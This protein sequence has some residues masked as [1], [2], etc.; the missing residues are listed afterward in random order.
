MRVSIII[1]AH[2]EERLLP[3]TLAALQAA[4][5][6]LVQP[7][8]IIVVNDAST[9]RTAQIARAHGVRVLDVDL[10]QISAVRNAGA[11]VATGDVL[12]FVDADTLVPR[13]T[14]RMALGALR[15]G[16]VGG[17][18]Q[19]QF[20][21]IS[22]FQHQ[23]ARAFAS[24]WLSLMRLA[25][26]CFIFVRRE[27]FEAV[28]GFDERYFI[29]EELFLSRALKKRGHFVMLGSPVLTSSRKLETAPTCQ[30]LALT[31][32]LLRQGPPAWQRREGLE[33][34]YGASGREQGIGD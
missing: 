9:D 4:I 6:R 8:E 7:F 32:R 5:E 11:R 21:R 34:W 29:G 2:N 31:V 27:A 19:V 24:L 17:G 15:N 12:V 10:R 14:L 18:A 25:A 33:L 30:L 23:F 13:A 16:A 22:W 1:P 26:G 20:E 3:H 28:G